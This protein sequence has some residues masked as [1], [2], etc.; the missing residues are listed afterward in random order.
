MKKDINAAACGKVKSHDTRMYQHPCI[1]NHVQSKQEIKNGYS[2]HSELKRI[3][4]GARNSA[5]T[6]WQTSRGITHEKLFTPQASA[7]RRD[8]HAAQPANA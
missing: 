3:F 6:I 7:R 8:G 4:K 5:A 2:Q 1:A